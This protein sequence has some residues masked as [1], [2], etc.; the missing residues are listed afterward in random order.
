MKVFL[1]IFDSLRKDHAGSTYGNNWIQTPN[2]DRFATDSLVFEKVYPESLA[3]IPVRRTIHTGLRTFPFTQEIPQMRTDDVVK[4]P[5]WTPIPHDQ[6]HLS[7]Y[8]HSHGYLTALITST[9]HYF[10]PNMNF[11]LGYDQW[12][13][14]RGQED[15]HYRAYIRGDKGSINK[16]MKDYVVKKNL[17]AKNYQKR[18]LKSYFP[19]VQDRAREEDYFPA[20]T[21]NKALEFIK[22]TQSAKNTFC[23]IDEFD[24]HEPW[25]PPSRFLNLYLHE[26]YSGSKV[27]TPAYSETKDYLSEEE[28]KYMRA[29]Y[30]GEVSMCDFWFGKFMDE[31]KQ[32]DLYD[33]SLI[34]L[35]SDHGHSIGE[36]EAIGKLPQ[37]MYPELV[38]IPLM[39]KPPGGI[40]GPKRIKKSYVY[41]HDI[42]ATILGFISKKVPEVF[43]GIDLSFY[44]D[45]P[46]QYI[47][48]RDYITCGFNQHTLY[49]DDNFGFITSNDRTEQK[50]YDLTEDPSWNENIARNNPNICNDLFKKVLK[51]ANGKLL[52]DDSNS[53]KED[54][55]K[56]W[57]VTDK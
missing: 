6:R 22:D 17:F 32:M 9:Y 40:K 21:F 47:T 12:N 27:I 19:N 11:H 43:E 30:A 39:I 49:K 34:L 48:N 3:T 46:D 24:P 10:K 1:I 8:L 54:L 33:D 42:T 51:D 38:D 41:H 31:L 5:G 23:F 16:M 7:E 57:Y 52:L 50:L 14:I 45:E 53:N 28:L 36:H 18:I 55:S 44:F 26:Q 35:T 2:F 25:D 37:F 29:C 56:Y 15:D 4:L 13:W 20:R